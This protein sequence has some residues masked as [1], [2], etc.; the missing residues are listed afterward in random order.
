[1]F[2]ALAKIWIDFQNNFSCLYFHINYVFVVIF[3]K[4]YSVAWTLDMVRTFRHFLKPLFQSGDP[5]MDI[6]KENSK[7]YFFK[8]TILVA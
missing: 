1:M 5:K 6:Y 7:V 3:F 8:I 4:I 2:G